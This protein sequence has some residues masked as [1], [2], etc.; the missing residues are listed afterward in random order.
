[1]DFKMRFRFTSCLQNQFPQTPRASA[2]V[3]KQHAR[4]FS[5]SSCFWGFHTQLL[6]FTLVRARLVKLGLTD[7]GYLYIACPRAPRSLAAVSSLLFAVSTHTPLSFFFSFSLSLIHKP[8]AFFSSFIYKTSK[9]FFFFFQPS[10]HRRH[11]LQTPLDGL[12]RFT[13]P[14]RRTL[15]PISLPSDRGIEATL[16]HD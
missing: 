4:I 11:T 2:S 15:S 6:I 10:A 12:Y 1:M 13:F 5:S 8:D 9:T 7:T 16:T 14:R 3:Q